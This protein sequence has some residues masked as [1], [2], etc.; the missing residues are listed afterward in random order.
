MYGVWSQDERFE[1]CIVST[2]GETSPR[3]LYFS[4][5]VPFI[6]PVD[7]S[8]DG[9]RI[10]VSYSTRDQASRI[11]LLSVS[12]GSVRVLKSVVWGGAN[13]IEFSP[14]GKYLAYDLMRG[15]D[16]EGRDIFVLAADGSSE[17]LLVNSGFNSVLGWSADGKRVVFLRE[18]NGN[19]DIWAAPVEGNK[20]QG[21]PVR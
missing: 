4:R 21:A 7:W 5:E 13:D 2:N 11:G 20:P 18:R 8:P 6:A 14:D 1:L 15:D 12:D 3:R 9:T 16:L 17:T 10:A 19:L